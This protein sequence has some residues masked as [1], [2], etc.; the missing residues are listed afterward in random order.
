MSSVSQTAA[1]NFT[2]PCIKVISAIAIA[3]ALST[4]SVWSLCVGRFTG[5][6]D[7]I[8]GN[9]LLSFHKVLYPKFNSGSGLSSVG[10]PDT[11]SSL[12]TLDDF[13]GSQD[14][15]F[16]FCLLQ[17]ELVHQIRAFLLLISVGKANS[18]NGGSQL[19]V[20]LP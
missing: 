4:I 7:L 19:H 20:L 12:H 10:L 17:I 14:L 3:D 15:P 13:F 5:K 1:S 2:R 8:A 11:K 9:F 18:S 6:S 16:S